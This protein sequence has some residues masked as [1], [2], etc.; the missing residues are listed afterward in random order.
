MR[1]SRRGADVPAAVE[2][3]DRRS[4]GAPRPL[5]DGQTDEA[6][7]RGRMSG[8][9]GGSACRGS[10]TRSGEANAA[11]AARVA[12]ART[13]PPPCAGGLLRAAWAVSRA[14]AP[15]LTLS[16][17]LCPPWLLLH[18]DVSPVKSGHHA[19][20][21][22]APPSQRSHLRSAS[23]EVYESPHRVRVRVCDVVQR[24]R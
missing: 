4:G 18:F 12:P 19:A 8:R 13:G 20:S 11:G 6:V 23:V 17:S 22:P 15:P 2:A 5:R 24:R 14:A 7:L 9:G 3:G 16:A 21:A 10:L 1:Q